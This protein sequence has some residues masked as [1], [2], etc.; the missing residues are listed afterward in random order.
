MD[1]GKDQQQ[2][3]PGSHWSE[4]KGIL[5]RRLERKSEVIRHGC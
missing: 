5:G 4:V 1:R 3:R 2:Q